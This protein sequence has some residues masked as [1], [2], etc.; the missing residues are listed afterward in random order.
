MRNSEHVWH[1]RDKYIN[2][3]LVNPEGNRMGF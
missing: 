2:L 1:Y 3:L